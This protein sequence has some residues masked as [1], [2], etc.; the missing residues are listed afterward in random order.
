MVNM[1]DQLDKLDKHFNEG[2]YSKEV[3]KVETKKDP[4]EVVHIEDR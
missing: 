1:F 2:I 3:T 4:E